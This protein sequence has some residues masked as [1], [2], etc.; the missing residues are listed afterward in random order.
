M[1]ALLFDGSPVT[2]LN[3]G[4]IMSNPKDS[5]IQPYLQKAMEGRRLLGAREY[6]AAITACN[7][8]IELAPGSLL[9][10]LQPVE[11]PSGLGL[12][13]SRRGVSKG[14]GRKASSSSRS[15][16]DIGLGDT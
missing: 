9:G 5:P 13:D 4:P 7:E 15:R 3:S 11:A 8:A 1:P 12:S 2:A 10:A 6:E 14:P 16:A